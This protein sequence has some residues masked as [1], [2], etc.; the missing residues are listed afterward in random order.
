MQHFTDLYAAITVLRQGANFKLPE[1]SGGKTAGI[2]VW[3]IVKIINNCH[4]SI[5]TLFCIF[6]MPL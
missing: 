2:T 5:E 1:R 3:R 6:S 4:R